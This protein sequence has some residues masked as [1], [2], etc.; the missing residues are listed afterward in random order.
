MTNLT[1]SLSATADK[2]TRSGDIFNLNG[3]DYDLSDLSSLPQYVSPEYDDNGNI[4]KERTNPET[5][6]VYTDGTDIFIH[7]KA[8][9]STF[10]DLSH[11]NLMRIHDLNNNGQLEVSEFLGM[12]DYLGMTEAKR[13]EYKKEKMDEFLISKMSGEFHKHIPDYTVPADKIKKSKIISGL[14]E[15]KQALFKKEYADAKKEW[16]DKGKG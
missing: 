10:D 13:W 8:N 7:Y 16:M 9:T 6:P 4:T 15:E 12:V 2:I 11:G 1:F 14:S 5:T 3:T